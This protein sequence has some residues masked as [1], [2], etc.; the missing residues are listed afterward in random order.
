MNEHT[1][2]NAAAGGQQLPKPNKGRTRAGRAFYP[3]NA[4]AL[5]LLLLRLLWAA[6]LA[7]WRL[8]GCLWTGLCPPLSPSPAPALLINARLP[9]RLHTRWLCWLD[10]VRGCPLLL[11]FSSLRFYSFSIFDTPHTLAQSSASRFRQSFFTSTL[12][13]SAIGS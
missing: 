3:F 9:P 13:P 5:L 6:Q 11:F 2:N 4:S 7:A 1:Q 8:A 10:I 12:L